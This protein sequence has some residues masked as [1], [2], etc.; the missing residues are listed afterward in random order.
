MDPDDYEIFVTISYDV[1]ILRMVD[2]VEYST[3]FSPST[4][5]Q[6]FKLIYLLHVVMFPLPVTYIWA[7]ALQDAASS[8]VALLLR[9]IL[10]ECH[11][12]LQEA[13]HDLTVRFTLCH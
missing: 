9:S 13:L 11:R 4:L 3:H 10:H 5:R 7:V 6:T 12:L 8:A 1:K 2:R